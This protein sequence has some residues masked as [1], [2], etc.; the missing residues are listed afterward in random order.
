VAVRESDYTGDFLGAAIAKQG[1]TSDLTFV[2][3]DID[4]RNLANL[5][6][7]AATNQGLTQQ[8]S[9]GVA[10]LHAAAAKTMTLGFPT[11]L[12][13]KRSLELRVTVNEPGV[14]QLL[15]NVVHGAA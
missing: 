4:G 3:L 1:G 11:P 9:F 5:S 13:Y 7:A 2:I 14:V 6:Y 8:N 15:G 10:L 12:L